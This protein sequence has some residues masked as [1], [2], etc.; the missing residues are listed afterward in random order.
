[1]RASR[2]A[3]WALGNHHLLCHEPR[4]YNHYNDYANPHHNGN[5]LHALPQRQVAAKRGG[6]E[7]EGGGVEEDMLVGSSH[8]HKCEG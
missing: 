3:P 8:S 5:H 2:G 7:R 4:N 6:T 1:M